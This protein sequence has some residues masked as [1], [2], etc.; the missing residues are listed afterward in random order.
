MTPEE[1]VIS[2][3]QENQALRERVRVQQSVIDQQQSVIEGLQQQTDRL[4]EQVQAL[5]ERLKK[6]SHNSHLPPVEPHYPVKSSE[7]LAKMSSN[8]ET[9]TT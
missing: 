3:R 9:F 5:Q 6:D 7:K 4:S 8:K 2:L 1:E